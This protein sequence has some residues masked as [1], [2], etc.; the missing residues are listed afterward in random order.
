[1]LSYNQARNDD[2][3]L[4]W[5]LQ[6]GGSLSFR[7]IYATLKH[8]R[9]TLSMTEVQSLI[10]QHMQEGNLTAIPHPTHQGQFFYRL[11]P[12]VMSSKN[13]GT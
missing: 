2:A 9:S 6:D 7:G 12:E 4:Y 5:T 3:R 1:M 8:L 10:D 13:N 11:S